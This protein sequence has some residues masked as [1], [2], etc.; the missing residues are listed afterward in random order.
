[1]RQSGL[2]FSIA[3]PTGG[4]GRL[5]VITPRRCGSAPQRNLIRRRLKHIFYEER[6]FEKSFDMIVY[7]YS[8]AADLPFLTLKTLLLEVLSRAETTIKP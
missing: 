5:L 8:V 6:L 1:M 3:G 7:V 4:V 2:S